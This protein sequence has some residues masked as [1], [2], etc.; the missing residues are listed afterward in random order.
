MLIVEPLPCTM[1]CS[2]S[3]FNFCVTSI[4]TIFTK[5]KDFRWV[6]KDY[7]RRGFLEEKSCIHDRCVLYLYILM[8]ICLHFSL[9]TIFLMRFGKLGF[10]AI[11][12]SSF[13]EA[14]WLAWTFVADKVGITRK[15][16]FVSISSGGHAEICNNA[17]ACFLN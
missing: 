13:A 16:A 10:Y 7:Q 11:S 17:W 14:L 1:W 12:E 2:Q 5:W 4:W 6:Y 3:W 9:A 15:I 8:Q